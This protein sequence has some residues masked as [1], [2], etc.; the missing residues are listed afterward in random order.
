[1]MLLRDLVLGMGVAA[2]IAFPNAAL[3]ITIDFEGPSPGNIVNGVLVVTV[4]GP[5]G[6]VDVTFA[7]TGLQFVQF[8]SPPFPTPSRVLATDVF[9]IPEITITLSPGYSFLSAEIGNLI[10]G[11]LNN[12]NG[13]F[14]RIIVSAFDGVGNPIAS[15]T[16]TGAII[17]V[18]AANAIRI[19]VDDVPGPN[20]AGGLDFL[21]F[22]IDTFS[23]ELVAPAAE[24]PVPEP[25]SLTALAIGLLALAARRRRRLARASRL[26]R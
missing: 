14:D 26:T 25:T 24:S 3:P 6:P 22:T 20:P 19:T 23:F 11:S 1:M 10:D 17:H 4:A 21:G 2:G 16:G 12:G 8:T 9:S 5:I 13:E 15:T 18:D 7:G